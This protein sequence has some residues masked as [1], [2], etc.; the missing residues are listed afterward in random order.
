MLTLQPCDY[1]LAR[2]K[3][4]YVR[5]GFHSPPSDR[6]LATMAS[7]EEHYDYLRRLHGKDIEFL[8]KTLLPIKHDIDKGCGVGSKNLGHCKVVTCKTQ[9]VMM[10]L[11]SQ[12][13]TLLDTQKEAL[14]LLRR[15]QKELLIRK[16]I[17]AES[18]AS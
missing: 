16:G 5:I 1:Y 10:T 3:D 13:K 18:T 2:I 9:K 14:V 12:G 4:A 15:S 11:R 7:K 17:I 6:P 8:G